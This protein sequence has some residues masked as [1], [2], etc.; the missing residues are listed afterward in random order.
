MTLHDKK[1]S[2]HRRWRDLGG[3]LGTQ[4]AMGKDD[5]IQ[6]RPVLHLLL[7]GNLQQQQQRKAVR[8]GTSSP[9]HPPQMKGFQTPSC[10][11]SRRS[12][13]KGPEGE[14]EVLAVDGLAQLIGG[15]E[16]QPQR[17]HLDVARGGADGTEGFLCV[18][19]TWHPQQQQTPRRQCP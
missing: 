12:Y 13:L 11:R 7:Y 17:D 18:E 9:T 10:E 6:E 4:E 3:V 15:L 8:E 19:G 14:S 5:G 2:H 16:V 1:Q